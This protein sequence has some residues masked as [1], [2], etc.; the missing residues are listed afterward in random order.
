MAIEAGAGRRRQANDPGQPSRDRRWRRVV[1]HPV[2]ISALVTAA[3]ALAWILFFPRVGTDLSAAL[4][5]A[6]WASHYPGSAYLFSWYGGIH[7]ASY[8]LLAPYVL[9]FAG[10][11]LSMA[12]AAVISAVLLSWLLVRHQVPRP[13]A[14][15]LWAAIALWTELSAGR[16]AFTL[17]LA[18]GL[19][20]VVVADVTRPR[21]AGRLLAAAA[22]ALL[23][24]LLSPVAAIFLGVVG[25]AFAVARHWAQAVVVIVA[26]SLPL[27]VMALLSDGGTQPFTVQNWLPPLIA[28]AAALLLIPRRWQ[29]VRA[30]AIIYGL[31]VLLTWA[32]PSLIGSNAARLGELLAGPLLVGLGSARHRWLLAVAL[33]GAAVW[34]IAQ[35]VA[36]L[37]QGNAVAYAP[38]TAALVRE[39]AALHA[40]TARVEAVPQYGHW[41]SQELATAVPL[42][43]GW[44]RQIDIERN[45]LFYRG[46]LT[47]DAYHG[48][49]RSNA[50][51]YVAISGATPDFA[52]VAETATIRA[53]QPWLVLVWHNAF[54][55]LYRVLGTRPL[56]SPPATVTGTTPAQ[57]TL[58]MSRAGSTIVRVHWSPLLRAT[59]AVVARAGPWT[60]LTAR[61]PGTYIL[62]A[63]Y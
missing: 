20:C 19:G 25:V 34:Q 3:G 58:R 56:A 31:G 61:R 59:G 2:V 63:P 16:A 11:R 29:M 55:R 36:D 4:A 10:T 6:D 43:R 30:G 57:I 41:E 15:A 33:S 40:D 8:S 52:A 50:V 12:V 45:P 49:L 47:P 51:R 42:A 48:W 37:R 1:S 7:P 23:C 46:I 44:E 28:V 13:R 17:G 27:G 38:Q 24:C 35:P 18:A 26:A 62:T 53:G 54:W 32:V 60:R 9:A 5:R 39:L 21:Y 14:A 22:L